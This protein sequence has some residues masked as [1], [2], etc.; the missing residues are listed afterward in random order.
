MVGD[1]L[2]PGREKRTKV[3][4][5]IALAGIYLPPCTHPPSHVPFHTCNT[6]PR[7]SKTSLSSATFL[8]CPPS[9]HPPGGSSC[10]APRVLVSS[11]CSPF[12]IGD[13][14]PGPAQGIG[15]PGP[16]QG[17]LQ[18]CPDGHFSYYFKTSSVSNSSSQASIR[19]Q[20]MNDPPAGHVVCFAR[21]RTGVDCSELSCAVLHRGVL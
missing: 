1:P 19:G 4:L 16:R 18:N 8:I 13:G 6:H 15:P 7:F 10:W 9:R 14:Q 11:P 17:I 2:C 5:I 20:A 21:H 3:Y 12:S